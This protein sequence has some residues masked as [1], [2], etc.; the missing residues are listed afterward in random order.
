MA[1]IKRL[2]RPKH[3]ADLLGVS[4][5]TVG[6]LANDESNGFPKRIRVGAQAI[7][8]S[9]AEVEAWLESRK[10]GAAQ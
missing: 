5:A 8:F 7:A 6:R 4:I 3:L 9:W 2:I 10:M 1:S